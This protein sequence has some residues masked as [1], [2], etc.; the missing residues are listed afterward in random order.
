LETLGAQKD[1]RVRAILINN[2][3]IDNVE[4]NKERIT[5]YMAM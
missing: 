3:K 5:E 1:F 4:Q 2:I